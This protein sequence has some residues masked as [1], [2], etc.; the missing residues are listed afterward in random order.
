M[1]LFS[2]R[3]TLGKIKTKPQICEALEKV[4]ANALLNLTRKYKKWH[5]TK[6]MRIV[7]IAPAMRYTTS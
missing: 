3:S 1:P 5:V 7:A 6:I 2:D 4:H